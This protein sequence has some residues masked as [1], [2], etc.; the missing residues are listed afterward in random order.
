MKTRFTIG[1]LVVLQIM[2]LI[3]LQHFA[4]NFYSIKEQISGQGFAQFNSQGTL[5]TCAAIDYQK[6]IAEEDPL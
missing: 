5:F 4:V 3:L 1:T 2:T 6:P